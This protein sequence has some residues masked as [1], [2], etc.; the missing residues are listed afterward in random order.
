MSKPTK[1]IKLDSEDLMVLQDYQLAINH[2]NQAMGRYLGHVGVKKYG[3]KEGE[4]Y[5]FDPIWKDGTVEVYLQK[6]PSKL[7]K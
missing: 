7:E 5:G 4:S 3:L 1:I 6:K 2:L